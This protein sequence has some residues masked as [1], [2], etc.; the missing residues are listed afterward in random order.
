AL[1][2]VAREARE[3]R[4]SILEA[5]AFRIM[6]L[7]E[8][9]N[10]RALD[11]LDKADSALAADTTASASDVHAE[12]VQVLRIRAVRSAAAGLQA[13]SDQALQ[14]MDT[15]VTATHS[16]IFRR[17]HNGALGCVLSL[18]HQYAKAV[19]YLQEDAGSPLSMQELILAYS[20]TGA[21]DQAH[22]L[23]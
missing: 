23:E 18:G 20:Q 14:Q 8:R 3:A 2:S 5:E 12:Q 11:Y 4:L 6:A 17:S 9:D 13:A 7:Y 1:N 22:V 10:S 21:T 16:P 19:P 15:L